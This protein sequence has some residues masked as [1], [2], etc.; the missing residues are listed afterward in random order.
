M[1]HNLK[2]LY[3]I[4]DVIFGTISGFAFMEMFPIL[5][6]TPVAILSSIDS[7]IKIGSSL[8]AFI[9]FG[10]RTYFFVLKSKQDVKEKEQLIKKI[11]L[12][13][14]K[15]ER[16]Q[17]LFRDYIDNMSQEDFEKSKN[18]LLKK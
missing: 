12:E 7:S 10:F 18:Q 3:T 11:E 2:P 4:L 17:F 15:S 6:V 5:S 16:Q 14:N 1:I 9:Y 13:N 8:L